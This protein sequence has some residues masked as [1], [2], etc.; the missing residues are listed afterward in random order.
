MI[1]EA[2]TDML[3]DTHMSEKKQGALSK[4]K[5]ILGSDSLLI[6]HFI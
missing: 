5:S 3:R 6:L 4:K 2:L 1:V